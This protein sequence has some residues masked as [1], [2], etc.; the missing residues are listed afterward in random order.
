MLYLLSMPGSEELPYIA[1]VVV[2]FIG[3]VYF[4]Y[5]FWLGYKNK[6]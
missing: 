6:P 4:A 5:Y 3:I 1:A 2:L